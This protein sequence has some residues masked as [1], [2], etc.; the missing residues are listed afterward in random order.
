MQSKSLIFF[1]YRECFIP[2]RNKYWWNKSTET[3]LQ[4]DL[5]FYLFLG[6]LTIHDLR[7]N[8]NFNETGKSIT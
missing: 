8:M 3:W 5:S 4:T 2:L 7:L 1:V 6:E